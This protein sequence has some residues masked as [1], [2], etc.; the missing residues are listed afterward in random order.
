MSPEEREAYELKLKKEEEE[1]LNKPQPL[2]VDA[3]NLDVNSAHKFQASVENDGE[4]I[5][6]FDRMIREEERQRAI[7]NH[8]HPNTAH[9]R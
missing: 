9:V 8:E 5:S 6:A 4:E 3:E 7:M 2:I 1:Q